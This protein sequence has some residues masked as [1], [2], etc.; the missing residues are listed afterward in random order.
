M[1]GASRRPLVGVALLLLLA[2]CGSSPEAELADRVDAVTVSANAGRADD[3]RER[4]GE[5][6]DTVAQQ[7]DAG[8]LPPDR[9]A[10]LLALA[11]ALRA[12]ADQVDPAV[13][14][15][16]QQARE[17]AARDA[18]ARETAARA[19]ADRVHASRE[20]PAASS[21]APQPARGSG[22]DEQRDGGK[23]GGK[24]K[25]DGKDGKD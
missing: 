12:G 13:R 1:R 6:F 24:G 22:G 19:D 8:R 5:L 10:R 2:G 9:A 23:G 15:R 7:R 18:A 3:L 17:A 20:S 21:A 16:E 4:A 25:G 14:A 11:D